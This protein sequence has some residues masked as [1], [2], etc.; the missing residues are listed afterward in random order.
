MTFDE[1]M[2][3]LVNLSTKEKIN[4]AITSYME[5]LPVLKQYDPDTKGAALACAIIGTAAAAD[6]QLSNDEAAFIGGL[7]SAMNINM[8]DNEIFAF[9]KVHANKSAYDVVKALSNSMNTEQRSHLITLVAAICAMD[10]KIS[11]E[12]CAYICDLL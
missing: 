3:G 6:G 12:E 8:S 2:Q 9:V 5:L 10:D 4:L 7:F 11:R 1:M